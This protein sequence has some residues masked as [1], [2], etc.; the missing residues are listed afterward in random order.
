MVESV[1]ARVSVLLAVKVFP[2]AIVRVD[3]V[4]GAVRATLLIE[5]AEATP[6]VGVTK[7]ADVIVGDEIV[8]DAIVGDVAKTTPPDPVTF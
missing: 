1:P 4:A 7:V 3:P 5:V 2:S 8:G 6:R